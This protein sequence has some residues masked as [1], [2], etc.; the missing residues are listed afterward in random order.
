EKFMKEKFNFNFLKE[1]RNEFLTILILRLIPLIPFDVISYGAG[2]S[3]IKYKNFISATIL[4][5]IPGVVVFTNLGDKSLNFKSI[6]FLCAIGL[7]IALLLI[8]LLLK[9]KTKYLIESD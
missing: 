9:K 2:F 3:K 8:S 1:N 4:G 7:L 6:E 5:I